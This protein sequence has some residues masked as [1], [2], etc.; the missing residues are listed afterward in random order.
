MAL[1]LVVPV[2]AIVGLAVD[3]LVESGGRAL[4]A[5]L[6][7]SLT[8]VSADIAGVTQQVQSERMA[9]ARLVAG[10]DPTLT[11]R[12]KIDADLKARA[13]RYTAQTKNTDDAIARYNR[14]RQ[15]LRGAPASISQQLD[16]VDQKLGTINLLRQQVLNK[17]GVSVG[18]MVLRYG[19]VIDTM[20]AFHGQLSQIAGDTQ[21]ANSL[22]AVAAFSQAK[23]AASL[24][25]AVGFASLLHAESLDAEAQNSFITTLT[26]QESA[27]A[28]FDLVASATQKTL[29]HT[30][31]TGDAVQLA[32]HVADEFSRSVQSVQTTGRALLSADDLAGA[33]GA[34]VDLMRYTEQQLDDGLLVDAR[35]LRSSIINQVVIQS[36]LVVVT[37][38]IAVLITAG[39]ARGMVRALA[40]LREGALGVA[41]RDLPEAV[42]R[43]RDVRDIGENS[44]E[45]IA[46][47]VRD[48]IQIDS[49][50]E[51]GQVAQAFNVVHREAVR[52][53]AEQASLRT[54]VSAMF[55]NLARRSQALVDRMI[56]ELDA[57]ERGEEDPK[58]LARLFQLD[59]LATRM[60]RNDENLLVLAGAD[61]SAPR[62]E[63]APLADVVRAAQSEV[64]LY[65]RIEFGTIDPD[66]SIAARAVND[67]VRL[68]AELFDNST[69]FSPP[70]ASVLVDA[71][72]IGDYVLLQVE[73]HGLGMS[74]QQMAALNERLARPPS[75]DIAAFRMMGLAV[76]ARLADRYAIRVTLQAN[77]EGGTI[78]H[79]TLPSAILILPRLRGREPVVSRPRPPLA[80]ERG[81][82]ASNGWPMPSLPGLM[83]HGGL[84]MSGGGLSTATLNGWADAPDMRQEWNPVS[85]RPAAAPAIGAT[86]S[87]DAL[88]LTST[89]AQRRVTADETAELPIFREAEAVWFR[90]HG[91]RP[92]TGG[93]TPAGGPDDGAG[94]AGHEPSGYE[95]YTTPP[96][97]IVPQPPSYVPSNSAPYV[98]QAAVPPPLPPMS[99]SPPSGAMPPP[100]QRPP[101]EESWQTAADDGWRRAAAA[102]A[103]SDGGT[104][105]S[106]LPKRVPAAQL[107]PGGIDTQA[108]GVKARRTPDEVRGLLSAYHRGVQRGRSGDGSGPA[109]RSSDEERH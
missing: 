11:D 96:S 73:D 104:T 66:V 30:I 33:V 81:P 19:V 34:V 2:L 62:R 38:I 50:D 84:P 65:N 54:S 76:V 13:D 86:P 1:I 98:P 9:G 16:G 12:T 32:D 14:D 8:G 72:R 22:R 48:P 88:G 40:R 28:A 35:N 83:Q 102:S 100:R 101:V 59:H 78:T 77:P 56:G 27:L 37:L 42:A 103:P 92:A 53:A 15:G 68:L 47:Q 109:Q 25:E 39:L 60:R 31:I 58:R 61:S 80:V 82:A 44:P 93:W 87:I 75:V 63:D 79:L 18:E 91:G 94:P 70:T 29:V 95:S 20:V 74:E 5:E 21:L 3:R 24:E 105:R 55:L 41:S 52:V 23:A 90:S 97:P 69:R 17:Q 67:V 108:A 107:V 106:G 49:R 43:L 57:I 51:I 46:R 45:E 6:V 4:N 99:A 26:S 85:Q 64:E 10:P 71:R 7:T 89:G 36:I